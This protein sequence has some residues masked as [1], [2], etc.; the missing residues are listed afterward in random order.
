MERKSVTF[1]NKKK[2]IKLR[3]MREMSAKKGLRGEENA[4][5]SEERGKENGC[6]EEG[7]KMVCK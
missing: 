4:I 7:R 6:Q 2:R 5:S 1:N 3:V